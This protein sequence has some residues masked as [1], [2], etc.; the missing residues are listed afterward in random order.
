MNS[1]RPNAGDRRSPR[2]GWWLAALALVTAALVAATAFTYR[3]AETF[4][5]ERVVRA[6]VLYTVALENGARH[7]G[8][9]STS[10][11]DELLADATG[12][13]VKAL[14]LVQRDGK[15]LAH[16]GEEGGDD[17]GKA[18]WVLGAARDGE[19][20]TG[21]DTGD[22]LSVAVPTRMGCRKLHGPRGRRHKRFSPPGPPPAGGMGPGGG[23]CRDP[24]LAL[25]LRMDTTEARAPIRQARAQA[26]LVAV[27]VLL[28]WGL[29]WR[30]HR[31]TRRAE[32]LEAEARRTEKLAALGEMAAVMA[33][34]IR[35]PLGAIR[36][37]AQLVAGKLEGDDRTSRSLRTIV[38]ETSRLA[39]LVDGLLRYARPR[40]PVTCAVDLGEL[41]DRVLAL[42]GEDASASGVELQRV[43]SDPV[44]ID[45][46]PDQI[47]QVLLNLV[48]NAIG[49]QPGGGRVEVRV[50]RAADGA[51]VVVAD[52]GPGIPEADWERVFVPFVTTGAEG[53]GLGLAV[54][55]QIAEAHGGTL[56]AGRS[57]LGGAA[58][59]LR[60]PGRPA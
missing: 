27:A 45:C 41:T 31:V 13:E 5:R 53:T 28:A 54:A 57:E 37:H 32:R 60:L 34:E 52:A 58:L 3:N 51:T 9:P 15:V 44:S 56:T 10:R 42:L 22:T 20:V 16:A 7:L 25:V 46:D 23:P 35:N 38:D 19:V 48:R 33:H 40:P 11:I 30:W 6:A 43:G 8:P 26:S 39:T 1:L 17:L 29:A 4:A 59:A 50:S 12:E 21:D 55:R 14:A 36:G 18:Y 2:G 49:V 24:G 47:E